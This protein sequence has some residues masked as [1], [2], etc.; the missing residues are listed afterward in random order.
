MNGNV[1]SH[2]IYMYVCKETQSSEQVVEI[3]ARKEVILTAGAYESPHLLL[4]SGV[5]SVDALR[6][7]NID[8]VAGR[9]GVGQHLQD[10]PVAALRYR[11]GTSA[12]GDWWP[13]SLS[14]L[15][16][17]RQ[18]ATLIDY[19]L[20]GT[21]PFA[22]SGCDFG[23]FGSSND[24]YAGRPDLQI[25]GFL[26][27]GDGSFYRDFLRWEPPWMSEQELAGTPAE[28]SMLWSQGLNIA[29][30]LLHPVATGSVELNTDNMVVQ[31]AVSR[32]CPLPGLCSYTTESCWRRWHL[33]ASMKPIIWT[34]HLRFATKHSCVTLQPTQS[35]HLDTSTSEP[36]YCRCPVSLLKISSVE[37]LSRRANK[38]ISIA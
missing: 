37:T 2:N 7:A 13:M 18:P 23:Y 8:P 31:E 28:Y 3:Q 22:S 17:L 15:S 32:T 19:W 27:A 1:H 10:H 20:R 35:C 33:M 38:R 9:R 36:T 25:H 30:T 5:G 21:G 34:A 6:A 16:L 4:K 26:T 12:A 14:K 29:P 24:S 11:L